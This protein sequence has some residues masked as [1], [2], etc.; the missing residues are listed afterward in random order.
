M[1]KQDINHVLVIT[2]RHM[3]ILRGFNALLHYPEEI[4]QRTWLH[5]L[6]MNEM[7]TAPNWLG[8]A[9]WHVQATDQIQAELEVIYQD[10]QQINASNTAEYNG[11]T[12]FN[13]RGRYQLRDNV[14]VFARV[15]N[16]LDR[17]YADR[18]D[19]TFFNPDRYRYFPAMPRQFYAGVSVDF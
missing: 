10:E 14:A 5:S 13:L 1:L 19:W 11:H 12:V 17:D 15:I 3:W 16:L 8:S 18:A 9:A 2:A 4:A 6:A 7:D